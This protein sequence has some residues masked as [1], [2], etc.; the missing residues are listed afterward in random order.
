VTTDKP[1]SS[2]LVLLH[3][4]MSVR[5]ATL[6]ADDFAIAPTQH[7]RRPTFVT[8]LCTRT[9]GLASRAGGMC[10]TARDPQGWRRRH[11]PLAGCVG[12]VAL[13]SSA[14]S[15]SVECVILRM[16]F[17]C[18]DACVILL[19]LLRVSTWPCIPGRSKVVLCCLLIFGRFV[20]SCR[21]RGGVP[22]VVCFLP[23]E[24]IQRYFSPRIGA[25]YAGFQ[26]CCVVI[27]RTVPLGLRIT[28]ECDTAPCSVNRTPRSRLPSDT[29]AAYGPEQCRAATLSDS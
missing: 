16:G 2:A 23:S 26:R 11:P 14:C 19:F 15:Y 1:V 9:L 27:S 12:L 8:R 28:R 4:I 5:K 3:S 18:L 6:T 7:R 17:E 29:P 24:P 10:R 21:L 13:L 25:Y 22:T 20:L